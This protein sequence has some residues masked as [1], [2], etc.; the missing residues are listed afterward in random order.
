M[1]FPSRAEYEILLYSLPLEYSGQI[2]SSTLRLY[3]TSALTARV[4]GALQFA[5]GL[6]LRVREFLDFRLGRIL[7]YSYTVYR[8]TEK[9]RWYDPQPHPEVSALASTFPHHHHDLP[10]IK[11]N[12]CPAPGISFAALNLP[13]L[14]AD[15]LSLA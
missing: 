14:I 1:A 15:C 6:E 13:A 5:S 7:D 4:E 3:S 2:T 8:G 10:D 12:R 9:I 11:H